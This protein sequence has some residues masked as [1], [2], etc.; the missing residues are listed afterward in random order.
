M[1]DILPFVRRGAPQWL[2]ARRQENAA[3]AQATNAAASV[4]LDE[5]GPWP[6]PNAHLLELGPGGSLAGATEPEM[7][8][9]ALKANPMRRVKQLGCSVCEHLWLAPALGACPKCHAS[10][11]QIRQYDEHINMAQR[12]K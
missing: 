6:P 3:L 11:E 10:V 9:A 2:R 1:G 5:T 4:I 7:Q 12:L 8:A